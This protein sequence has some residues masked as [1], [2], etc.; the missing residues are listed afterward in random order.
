VTNTTAYYVLVVNCDGQKGLK[1]WPLMRNNLFGRLRDKVIKIF[2]RISQF[3]K[4]SGS[5]C[6]LP[7]KFCTI[8]KAEATCKHS[9]LFYKRETNYSK[10]KISITLEAKLQLQLQW[11]GRKQTQSTLKAVGPSFQP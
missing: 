4:I 1:L 2:R 9:S 3:C 5:V 10:N 7:N 8:Y 6:N 11:G